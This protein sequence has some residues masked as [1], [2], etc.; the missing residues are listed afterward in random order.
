MGTTTLLARKR[1]LPK[2][3]AVTAAVAVFAGILLCWTAMASAAAAP[4]PG[5]TGAAVAKIV[6]MDGE[7]ILQS[8]GDIIPAKV[9]MAVKD[10]DFVLTKQGSAQVVFNDGAELKVFPFSNAQIVQRQ[11]K[12]GFFS[13]TTQ[14]SRR[15]TSYVGKMWFKSGS[16]VSRNFLQTPTAVCGLRGSAADFGYDPATLN[17]MLNMYSGQAQVVGNVVRGFFDNPG[18][19]A[20]VK[21]QVYQALSNAYVQTQQA[22]ATGQVVQVASA[23]VV[24]LEVAKL[25]ATEVAKSNPDQMVKTQ[26]QAA[27][28]AVDASI[29]S[30]KTVVVAEQI[31]TVQTQATQAAADARAAGDTAKA[32]EAD[33]AVQAATVAAAQAAQAAAQAAA[34]AARAQTAAD[35][36]NVAQAQAQAQVAQNQEKRAET[37]QTR[38][39]E[40]VKNVVTTTVPTTVAPTTIAPTTAETTAATTA[41]PTTAETT[42]GPTTAETTA[43]TTVA[44]TTAATTTTVPTTMMTTISTTTTSSTSSSSTIRPT[45]P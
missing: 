5:K 19:S 38:T 35:A 34:A 6:A 21:S 32:A 18:I 36:L 29:A 44:P 3:P 26:A 23:K 43:A 2:R 8:G 1:L 31:K 14:L 20:A 10:G 40:A 16:S 24:A 37:V 12:T 27:T 9:N 30:A 7:V 4:A 39:M 22:A 42:V 15:I 13:R 25:A 45:S 11:E 28:A 33:K 41:A 17:S